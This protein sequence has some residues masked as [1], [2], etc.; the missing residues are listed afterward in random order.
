MK[1]LNMFINSGGPIIEGEKLLGQVSLLLTSNLRRSLQTSIAIAGATKNC[2]IYCL[3][4][5]RE[6][7]F[8]TSDIPS[9]T[10]ADIMREFPDIDVSLL[11][12]QESKILLPESI[13]SVDNRIQQ[14]FNFLKTVERNN[15]V[16]LISHLYFLKKLFKEWPWWYISNLGIIMAV[17]DL[18]KEKVIQLKRI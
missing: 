11:S 10:K 16:L 7:G 8:G 15:K 17:I 12:E 2:K 4:S 3:E 6:I 5:L 1:K 9:M 13:D 14:F 18:D